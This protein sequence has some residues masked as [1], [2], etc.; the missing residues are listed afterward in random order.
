MKICYIKKRFKKTSREIIEQ[1][2]SIISE[3]HSQGMK[4][5]LRQ[6]YYQFVA[7][8]L[9]KNTVQNYKRIGDIISDA[10]VAGL[11]DWDAIEDRTRG[12]QSLAMWSTPEE[13]LSAC[14]E[15]Y[16]TDKWADQKYRVEVW[17][18]KQALASVFW[19]ACSD[20]EV[21]FFACKGYTSQSEMWEAGYYRMAK[22]V[23][24]KQRPV[25]LHFGDHDPSGI[26]MTRDI[27]ERLTLF[28]GVEPIISR[29]ALNMEQIEKYEP[30]PNP[31]KE[32]DP[33]FEGYQRKYGQESWELDAL[34]PTVLRKLIEK[35]VNKFLNKAV[36]A[37]SVLRQE[38][39]RSELV[40]ARNFIS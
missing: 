29:I 26:D 40:R 9:I 8:A 25:I 23:R 13:M 22:Y 3:Y 12:L 16:R 35:N 37:N 21:P 20:C 1:A 32:S 28:T 4:L 24:N 33:R 19:D 36:W 2:N 39:Q 15:Q 18:E 6:L 14:I 11:V 30:P 10:R 31:A 27:K 38:A 5:T 7:R 34:E 17:I